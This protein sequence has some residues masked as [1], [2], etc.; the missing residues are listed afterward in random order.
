[1]GPGK[2]L[3][4]QASKDADAG[5]SQSEIKPMVHVSHESVAETETRLL[6]VMQQARLKVYADVYGF[7]EFPLDAFA[8]RAR[9]DALEL[10]RDDAVWSQLSPGDGP[11]ERFRIFRF[12]FPEGVDNSGFVGWLASRLKLEFG[13]GVFVICGQNS[14]DGG[15]F[16]YWGVPEMLGD[17]VIA[18]VRK[19]CASDPD[20]AQGLT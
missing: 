17:V 13:T 19:L 5:S 4:I 3:Q 12:H 6:R 9:S 1:M 18:Y 20:L 10:V 15:I 7:E 14:G 16:D 8:A 2:T 11:G